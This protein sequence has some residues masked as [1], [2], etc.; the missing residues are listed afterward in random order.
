[1]VPLDVVR[2]A[3]R[4]AIHIEQ[5]AE[6]VRPLRLPPW[7]FQ[8]MASPNTGWI[9]RQTAG[10]HLEFQTSAEWIH[11]DVTLTRNLPE[12]I[13]PAARPATFTAVV[14]N[15]PGGSVTVD[16]GRLIIVGADGSVRTNPGG[17]SNI[18]LDLSA[19][20]FGQRRNVQ[21]WLPHT[22][23]TEINA[24]R[25]SQSLTAAPP[26]DAPRW[27]HHGSSISH[28]LEAPRPI[29]AWPVI[30]ARRLGYQLTNLGFGGEA[31]VDPFVARTIRDLP[32]ELISLKLG[33]NPI[34]GAAMQER[35]FVPAVHGFL[36]TIRER[37]PETPIVLLSPIYC[38]L[39][40]TIPGPTIVTRDRL[41]SDASR[42]GTRGLLTLESVRGAMANIVE[43]RADTNLYYVDGR[44][45]LG[46]SD[47]WLLV[48]SLHPN[49]E[50]Y[51]LMADRFTDLAESARWPRP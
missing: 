40:E 49:P 4:G 48:D 6:G 39:H 9:A 5:T 46:E 47:A 17:S 26:S 14:D 19:N 20:P 18:R 35:V 41:F 31:M 33:I 2:A 45:L 15:Q 27:V 7:A 3:V 37:Q 8:Q 50:G 23:W 51:R 42:A 29:D 12:R 36:D 22:A 28:C 30:V 44:S 32:C 13:E 38:P 43:I 11:L 24:V 1:M 34:N 16:E 10:I 25:A 21:I